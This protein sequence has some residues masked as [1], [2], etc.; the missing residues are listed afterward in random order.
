MIRLF[1]ILVVAVSL[2][3]FSAVA[4]AQNQEI[5]H[6]VRYRDQSG[7]QEV[8]FIGTGFLPIEK[9]VLTTSIVE[10]SC[11]FDQFTQYVGVVIAQTDGAGN[12]SFTDTVKCQGT[13]LYQFDIA[14]TKT[15]VHVVIGEAPVPIPVSKIEVPCSEPNSFT[16]GMTVTANR[17]LVGWTTIAQDLLIDRVS[18][19][20]QLTILEQPKCTEKGMWLHVSRKFSFIPKSTGVLTESEVVSWIPTMIKGKATVSPVPGSAVES[21]TI[22]LL[23]QTEPE[24][25]GLMTV[26]GQKVF[27]YASKDSEK[28]RVLTTSDGPVRIIGKNGSGK[29]IQIEFANGQVGWVCDQLVKT[30]NMMD[31]VPISD[32]NM[33]TCY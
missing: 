5:H 31:I 7:G 26:Q 20:T 17:D 24:L 23:S 8:R 2:C 10:G 32:P 13:F 15:W 6:T 11:G 30:N 33:N 27:A 3:M 12:F 1:R 22:N 25:V 14:S 9:I 28:V 18:K 19:E 4:L 21:S 29:F 16:V